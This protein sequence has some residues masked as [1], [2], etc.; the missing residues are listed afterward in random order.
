VSIT[1]NDNE[2]QCDHFVSKFQ[3]LL[4]VFHTTNFNI[5][6]LVLKGDIWK[7]GVMIDTF[8]ENFELQNSFTS[9]QDETEVCR[10]F[11]TN[12]MKLR[13]KFYPEEIDIKVPPLLLHMQ[14]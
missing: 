8:V 2:N 10:L 6:N 14:K 4:D 3:E 7:D 13:G 9:N 5:D 11:L 12:Q 1:N